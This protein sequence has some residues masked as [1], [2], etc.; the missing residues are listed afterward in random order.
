MG[1]LATTV[2]EKFVEWKEPIISVDSHPRFHP[3]LEKI[4]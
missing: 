4:E 1:Y 3:T 2:I